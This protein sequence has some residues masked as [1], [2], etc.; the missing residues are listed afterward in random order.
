MPT[1]IRFF[2]HICKKTL[3]FQMDDE[4]RTKITKKADK[5][6]YPVIVPH[7]DHWAILYVDQDFKERSVVP[8]AGMTK[9]I[10]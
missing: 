1:T 5:W 4:T 7:S 10:D 6:P 2:C 8:T 9:K 3:T